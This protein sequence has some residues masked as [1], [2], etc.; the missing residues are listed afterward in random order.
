MSES[1]EGKK[2]RWEKEHEE[3]EKLDFASPTVVFLGFQSLVQ[4][5]S[6]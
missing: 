2:S 6:C 3:D 4:P 5:W 1:D